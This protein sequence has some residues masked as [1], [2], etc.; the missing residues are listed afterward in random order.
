M[1]EAGQTVVAFGTIAGPEAS[2][3]VAITSDDRGSITVRITDT[4]IAPGAPDVRV[5]LT[6]DPG[7]DVTVDGTIELGKVTA[8][9]GELVFGVPPDVDLADLHALVV[10]CSVYSVTFGVAPLERLAA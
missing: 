6:P 4:W 5:Y 1:A 3:R 8:L 7:G 10:Y 9:S 2:G